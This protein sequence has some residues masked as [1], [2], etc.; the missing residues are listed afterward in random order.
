LSTSIT[1]VEAK[2]K[3]ISPSDCGLA[4]GVP[5]DKE[6]FVQKLERREE[7]NFVQAFRTERKNLS[8][9]GLWSL[10]EPYAR[11]TIDVAARMQGLGVSVV[12]DS[13]LDHFASLLSNCAVVALVAQWRSALF[14]PADIADSA[15]TC[16]SLSDSTSRLAQALRQFANYSPPSNDG[17]ADT[18]ATLLNETLLYGLE[19]PSDRNGY[20]Q[21]VGAIT[22][23]Q[24]ELSRRRKVLDA[25][26]SFPG[27]AGVEFVEG[28]HTVDE[29]VSRFPTNFS[30]LVDLTVCNS[31]FL[32]ETIRRAQPNCLVLANEDLAYLDFRLATYA[33]V[34]RSLSRKPELYEDVVYRIHKELLEVGLNE[35][36]GR[37]GA[38]FRIWS[39]LWRNVRWRRARSRSY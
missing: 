13:T 17:D 25:V 38:L 28:F 39:A 35:A 11:F 2:Q 19:P 16:S 34:I 21:K 29:I 7:G 32:A 3:L 24:Y 15:A 1:K 30:G 31:V 26:G 10:Y 9:N 18:L 22:R 12:L 23:F 4:I 33:Q 36:K 6:A 20:S 5:L 37:S 14:K 8:A 27:G